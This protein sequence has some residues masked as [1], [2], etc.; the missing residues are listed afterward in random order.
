[1]LNLNIINYRYKQIIYEINLG[2][3]YFVV[4]SGIS[5]GVLNGD[6]DFFKK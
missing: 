2:Y 3:W 5:K 1:M 6:R 4:W